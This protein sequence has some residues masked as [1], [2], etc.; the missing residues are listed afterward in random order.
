MN[1]FLARMLMTLALASLGPHRTD[2]K[3]AMAIE[4]RAASEEGAGLPFA[5]GC[6]ATACQELPDH[7]EGRL[8][9]ARYSLTM[10]LILPAAALLIVGLLTGY[11]YVDPSYAGAI[12]CFAKFKMLVP[13]INAGNVSAVPV[14]GFI[15]LLRVGS[16][17]LV[18]WS[19]VERDWGRA[20]AALR[21]GAAATITLALFAGI[22]FLDET[23]VVLPVCTLVVELLVLVVL[24]RV[25]GEARSLSKSCLAL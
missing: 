16:D 4:F 7:L 13:R 19:A 2:W 22:A 20:A 12:G 9:L 15:L 10:S 1:A 3:L 25:H 21:F 24:Q 23:C 17:V 14:L 8:T 5:L 6:L 11:P 18:A